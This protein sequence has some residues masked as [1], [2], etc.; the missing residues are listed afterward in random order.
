[1][2]LL[3]MAGWNKSHF[4]QVSMPNG[5]L[6]G[7][8]LTLSCRTDGILLRIKLAASEFPSSMTS[9]QAMMPLK[10]LPQYYNHDHWVFLIKNLTERNPL[11]AH[12]HQLSLT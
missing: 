9:P 10:W 12:L 6:N 2:L 7:D 11:A 4:Q 5:M 3:G 8:V 1:M